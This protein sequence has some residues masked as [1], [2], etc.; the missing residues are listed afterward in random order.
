[1]VYTCNSNFFYWLTQD[2]TELGVAVIG[3]DSMSRL[4]FMR[5]LSQ[6]YRFITESL[7]GVVLL[8]FNKVGENTYPNLIPMLTGR[9][10]G[11]GEVDHYEV[12][13]LIFL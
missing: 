5:Q 1:M 9:P 2:D 10:H 4:N 12:K 8:G 6:S 11:Y 7:A 3:L 13:K